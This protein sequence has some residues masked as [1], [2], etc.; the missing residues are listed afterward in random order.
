MHETIDKISADISVL[1]NVTMASYTGNLSSG[2]LTTMNKLQK[3]VFT[4]TYDEK[5]VPEPLKTN[6]QKR[7]MPNSSGDEPG[8]PDLSN[9]GADLADTTISMGDKTD[10]LSN[11]LLIPELSSNNSS[12]NS[13]NF[14]NFDDHIV[15]FPQSTISQT[16]P[17][18]TASAQSRKTELYVTRFKNYVTEDMIGNYIKSKVDVNV[19]D[20]NISRLIPKDKDPSILSFVSFKID[21]KT[22]LTHTISDPA[23]WPKACRVTNFIRK[24][25]IVVEPSPAAQDPN[26][27]YH[28][29]IQ[30]SS[31]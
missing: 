11:T 6:E 16:F 1:K 8:G 20:I 4:Q 25:P 14:D 5:S 22:E 28:R 23:I 2:N 18:V 30:I 19:N 13:D 12:N 26:F 24:T 9:T 17:P 21:V 7:Q 3:E 15:P 29:P 31:I 10:F 27:L